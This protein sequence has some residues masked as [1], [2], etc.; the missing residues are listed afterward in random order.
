[1]KMNIT[2]DPVNPTTGNL[3]KENQKQKKEG[4]KSLYINML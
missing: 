1:M 4:K 3:Y 2:F